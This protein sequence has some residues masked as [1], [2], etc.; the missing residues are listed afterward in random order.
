MDEAVAVDEDVGILEPRDRVIAAQA[1][2][3]E[4]EQLAAQR[5]E[6]GVVGVGGKGHREG[7]GGR[8]RSGTLG[9]ARWRGQACLTTD[10]P[11]WARSSAIRDSTSETSARISAAS[12]M[13][14]A[15]A[16]A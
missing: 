8:G 16:V 7:G 11:S 6:G 14:V 10:S 3:E 13:S 2:R 9:G 5:L 1:G 12:N 15:P 4:G